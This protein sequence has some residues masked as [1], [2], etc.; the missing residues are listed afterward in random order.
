MSMMKIHREQKILETQ[1]WIVSVYH[2]CFQNL[3]GKMSMKGKYLQ[4]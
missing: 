3:K 4:G 1:E 2:F